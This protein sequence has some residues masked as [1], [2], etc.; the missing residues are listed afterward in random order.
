MSDFPLAKHSPS[1][2]SRRLVG[3]LERGRKAAIPL[4]VVGQ[5]HAPV[6]PQRIGDWW[7]EPY[8]EDSKLPPR[9][10]Q[11]LHALL[12]AGICPKAVVIFHEI[13]QQQLAPTDMERLLTRAHRFAAHDLP[14]AGYALGERAKAGAVASAPIIGHALA[15]G[16][17]ALLWAAGAAAVGTLMIAATAL[18]DPCLVI[19]TDD[20]YW[21]EVDRWYS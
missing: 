8:G 17:K 6:V 20:G 4:R 21:L 11:R 15:V 19:V 5:S 10:Q 7:L 3:V 12:D 9:A 18:S 2:P 13:P 1:L 14:A 16:G